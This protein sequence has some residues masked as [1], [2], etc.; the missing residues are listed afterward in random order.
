MSLCFCQGY[1]EAGSEQTLR[2]LY[3]PGLPEVF[4]KQITLQV[5]FLPPQDITV[6]GEGVFPRVLLNLP[7]KFGENRR[8]QVKVV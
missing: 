6:T 2:V 5:A 3:I 1:I 4:E 7:R 8:I